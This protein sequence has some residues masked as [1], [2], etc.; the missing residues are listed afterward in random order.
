MR[1]VL[2]IILY[3]FLGVAALFGM[4]VVILST[5]SGN[6]ESWRKQVQDIASSVTGRQVA[7]REFNDATIFPYLKFDGGYIFAAPYA[8]IEGT[9][10]DVSQTV[11]IRKLEFSLPFWSIF[12]GRPVFNHLRV[13]ELL[14]GGVKGF[15]ID[16]VQIETPQDTSPR[17]AITG[18]LKDKPFA[19]YL[20]MEKKGSGYA[21]KQDMPISATINDAEIQGVLKITNEAASIESLAYEYNDLSL[22][23]GLQVT[24]DK[25]V[26]L[27]L[28][29]NGSPYL[30]I[31]QPLEKSEELPEGV[32]ELGTLADVTAKNIVIS[33]CEVTGLPYL[34]VKNQTQEQEAVVCERNK[35]DEEN[36]PI[37]LD[38]KESIPVKDEAAAP[39]DE[40][41]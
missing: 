39:V 36:K 28:E 29:K 18:M 16:L 35:D 19:V 10:L 9:Q 24:L 22:S 23:G 38:L 8:N 15:S 11:I 40:T 6:S 21:P 1:L 4:G 5:Y 14:L 37:I 12:W 20:G 30:E 25:G 34:Y 17:L 27:S 26:S 2:K 7:I 3:F 13:E 31:T 41:E 32:V 33:F